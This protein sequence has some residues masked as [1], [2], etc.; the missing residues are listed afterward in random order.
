LIV[1]GYNLYRLKIKTQFYFLIA[2]LFFYVNGISQQLNDAT[3]QLK[4]I[5]INQDFNSNLNRLKKIAALSNLSDED[6]FQTHNL[7]ITNYINKNLLDSA[8]IHA[9][10]QAQ[11]AQQNNNFIHEARFLKLIGN[12][13]YHLKVTNKAVEYWNRCIIMAKKTNDFLL[14]EQCH[15]NIG[16]IVILEQGAFQAEPYF[17]KAIEFGK[18]V[19]GDNSVNLN[20]NYRL[21]AS[22]YETSNRLVK[23]DSLF[24]LVLQNYKLAKD[25]LGWVEA[26][27]F[28]CTVLV[29]NNQIEKGLKLNDS[30]VTFTR[31]LKNLEM[32]S[33]ALTLY[34]ANLDKAKRYD[35]LFLLMNEALFTEQKRNKETI[36]SEIAKAE[37]Q[38]KLQEVKYEQEQIIIYERQQR[39]FYLTLFIG[40]FLASIIALIFYYQ[41]RQQ[42]VKQQQE[43]EKIKIVFEA[44]EKERTRIA[45][46]LHDNMGSFATSILAQIDTL[47]LSKQEIRNERISN[48]RYDA[49]NIMS[50]L[51]ETI[52]ILKTKTITAS[53]FFNL[54][55]TYTNKQL[56]VNLDIPISYEEELVKEKILSP[57]ISLNLF[58]IVQEVTQNIIKHAQASSVRFIIISRDNKFSIQIIDDGK[59]F[60]PE[61]LTRKSG[62][63]NMMFRAQEI[64]YS[65]WIVSELNKGTQISL[66]E[67]S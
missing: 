60:N 11:H 66:N 39:I 2:L 20:K 64:N 51:R 35:K 1:Q 36:N 14:L 17:L 42:K 46:D 58:R 43:I 67:N 56:K 9:Q 44:E 59:G 50:T 34:A 49:E 47:E 12:T 15:H 48:L 30:I 53:H 26:A 19:K 10:Q 28:Y 24:Q 61:G 57:T 38:F 8:L 23:A 7:I 13:Y 62:L 31:Q 27:M 29:K 25:T 16:S 33:T 5:E 55:K 32:H 45:Q 40:I 52:W 54:V 6:Y 41:R 18:Q 63:E 3:T 37:T 65:I 4:Q 21:L 22:V